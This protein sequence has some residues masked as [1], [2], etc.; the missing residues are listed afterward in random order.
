MTVRIRSLAAGALGLAAVA[1]LMT[2]CATPAG[3]GAEPRAGSVSAS[4]SDS[5][6]GTPGAGAADD[7]V[8]AAWLDGGRMIGLVT[9]GS[10]A[11]PP[12]AEVGSAEA[13]VL[14]VTLADDPAAACTRDLAPRVTLLPV[15]AGV[16]PAQN[17]EIR[18]SGAG[19]ED[20]VELEG[21]PGLTAEGETD[22]SPSSGWA[23]DDQLVLLTWGSS[24][25]PPEIESVAVATASEVAITFATP[26]ADRVCTMDMAP[27]ALVVH[28]DDELDDDA[29]IFAVLRGAEFDDVRVPILGS[30]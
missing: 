26:P 30:N 29:E 9:Q 10:S 15:P 13:G 8:E 28:V 4:P 18:V 5:T 22:Y 24:G 27:R 14:H 3:P 17:L 7:D 20:D 11:C 12:T 19:Y 2:G 16:D 6:G 23:D 1:G 21:V 25:C